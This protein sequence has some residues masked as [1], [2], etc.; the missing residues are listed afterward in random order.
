MRAVF[1]A[2]AI[3]SIPSFL[4]A[5]HPMQKNYDHATK[6]HCSHIGHLF[7]CGH[8]CEEEERPA[9]RAIMGARAAPVGAIVESFPIMR[10]M[11]SMV[12]MPMM[13]MQTA[14]VSTQSGSREARSDQDDRLDEMDARVEALH[15]RMQ[16]IQRSVEL[17]T[18]ILL[19]LRDQGSIGGSP[20]RVTD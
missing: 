7:H 12:S 18:Q 4:F 13:A 2:T 19:E 3:A 10:A 9:N 17:Q 1:L 6:P 5:G 20:L 16:T 11:P 15:L 14:P 8:C